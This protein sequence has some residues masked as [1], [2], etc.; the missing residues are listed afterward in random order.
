MLMLTLNILTIRIL[1]LPQLSHFNLYENSVQP[2]LMYCIP[3]NRSFLKMLFGF[4][5]M[6][7]INRNM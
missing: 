4:L 6:V 1:L 5:M 3:C 2:N 7:I